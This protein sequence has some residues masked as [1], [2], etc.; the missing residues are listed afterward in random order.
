MIHVMTDG[1]DTNP[2]S[3]ISY[4]RDLENFCRDADLGE[5]VTVSGRF[6]AMDRDSRWERTEKAYQAIVSGKADSV[7][8]HANTCIEMSYEKGITDEFILPSVKKGYSGISDGDGIIFFNFR[9]DRAR[10]LVKALSQ[11][12]FSGFK[13]ERFPALAGLVCMTTYD[14]KLGLPAAFE[15]PK[16]LNTLGEVISKGGGKQLRIAE[17]EKYA[18]VTYFFNGGEEKPFENEKRILIPSNREVKTYDLKPEMS[19]V[20]ITE[21]MLQEL[22]ATEYQFVVVNFANADM[23]GHTGNLT[24]AVKAVETIDIC[25][26]KVLDW[27]ESQNAFAII[28]ADHGNCE[29]MVDDQGEPLTS[30]T[31]L[32][33]PFIVIDPKN[34]SLTLKKGG[35]LCDIAPTMLQIWGIE[36]PNDMTGHSLIN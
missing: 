32:S 2:T 36:Q 4:V 12:D 11:R 10:Q 13:R 26:K 1:R 3:G 30:H 35:K 18:H 8:S 24:A 9:A 29:K 22:K 5:V 34:P 28:T 27:V 19:A 33:V 25:L 6:Y 31:L 23:V 7:F 17:T 15:K 14:E 20:S 16:V 21:T